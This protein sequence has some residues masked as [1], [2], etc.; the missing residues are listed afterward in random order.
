MILSGKDASANL[1][2]RLRNRIE[3]LDFKPKLVAVHVGENPASATYLRI[4]E[5]RLK[6]LDLGFELIKF[7]E[8]IDQ[9]S[10]IIKIKELNAS[11]DVSGIIVQLPLPEGMDE[12]MVLDSIDPKK[13]VDCL[14]S[15]NLGKFYIGN[16]DIMPATPLGVLRL[17]EYYSIELTGK[18]ICVVGRSNLVGKPLAMALISRSA[19]VTICHSKTVDVLSATKKAE[20]IVS[21]VGRARFLTQDYFSPGQT[22]IDVG[23]SS[24]Q[25]GGLAGDVDFTSVA[26]VVEN[27]TPV[28][29]GVGPMTV[30]GLIENLITLAER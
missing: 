30:Y 14:T 13:D 7:P 21:A 28:P 5:K 4:K 29:G 2:D 26:E 15:V 3:R 24:D 12:R 19:T 8:T 23:T 25:D 1:Y 6:E 17:L 22:V 9:D 18:R 16:G 10:L 11:K 20:I 27:I